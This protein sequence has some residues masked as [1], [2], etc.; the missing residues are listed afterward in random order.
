MK[1]YDAVIIGAGAGGGA[2]AYALTQQGLRV[3]ILEAG[4]SYAPDKDYLAGTSR[5]Q[6]PFPQKA[7]SQGRYTYVLDQ[8]LSKQWAHLRSWNH[9]T[10]YLNPEAKRVAFAYH[11]VRG[12]G[13]SSL[14]FTGEAHRM[15]PKSMQMWSQHGV[16]AD[17]PVS[18]DMLEPY[19]VQAEN[20]VGVAGPENDGIHPRSA[21]YPYSPHA[22]GYTTH[23]L[24]KGFAAKGMRLVENPLAVL[25]QPRAQRL[26]CNYCNCCLK[27]CPRKDKGSI[28]VTYL[29]LA[30]AS[31]LCEIR[32]E[33]VVTRIIT[34]GA[35]DLVSGVEYYSAGKKQFIKT[36]LLILAAGAV[37]SPR[38]LLM[39]SSA[40]SPNG[41]CNES[42]QVGKNFME[43]LL[44]TSNALYHSD[45]ASYRGLPVDSICWDYNAP[46]AIPGVIGGCRFSPSVAESD[47]LGPVS[48]AT[49]VVKGWGHQHKQEMRRT[50]GRVVSLSGICESLP[51]PKSF[52]SLDSAVKD[53]FGL[54]VASIHSY[55]DEMATKRIAFM[56]K[57][58][59]DILKAMGATKIFEE[60]SSYD[61]FSSTHVFG[62]CRMGHD[63][64]H[65]VVNVDCRSHRW[66]NL[67]ILDASVFPSSGGGESPGLTIQAL[68]LRAMDRFQSR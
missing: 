27:G 18:Y 24:R 34:D 44:W 57:Q 26:N 29:Q 65:S 33:C 63:A 6:K 49:R 42:G 41:L 51:H 54:P 11:H 43:T 52:V 59:R 12:V 53:V 21:P 1:R 35:N 64:R 60:F 28:D 8:P 68:A 22:T 15:N 9:M 55:V 2:S 50:F 10:G 19:Y 7:G 39:S 3:L 48:Y 30:K 17:W 56:A 67:Y 36:P 46:D 61:I 25:P 13:G 37:E 14:H 20:I 38:L 31:G 45:L 4:P 32:T 47:L 16:A 5:W 23:L 40:D 58:C 66:R 62:T